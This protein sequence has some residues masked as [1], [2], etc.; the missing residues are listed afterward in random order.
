MFTR[1]INPI[2]QR[3]FFLFGARG[4]GKSTFLKTYF[5]KQRVLWFDLLDADLEDRFTLNPKTFQM[6]VASQLKKIDWVVID[7]IQKCP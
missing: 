1:L 5:K 4:V 7:E 2:K 3:S 6:E